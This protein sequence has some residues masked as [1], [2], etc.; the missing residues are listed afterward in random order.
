MNRYIFYALIPTN[1]NLF[2]EVIIIL[3]F[4]IPNND[5][6]L[7]ICKF[8]SAIPD[9]YPKL[10]RYSWS[11]FFLL[12]CETHEII[13]TPSVSETAVPVTN[14]NKHKYT[15]SPKC[16]I[17]EKVKHSCVTTPHNTEHYKTVYT[18]HSEIIFLF[19][20]SHILVF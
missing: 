11:T 2:R 7:C 17:Y 10:L 19:I 8:C 9:Y 14:T 6:L 20:T 16:L 18:S 5:T 12:C 13:S 15:F 4:L 3:F 1:S